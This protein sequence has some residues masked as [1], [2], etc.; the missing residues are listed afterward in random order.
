MTTANITITDFILDKHPPEP[1]Y[2]THF[3]CGKI[4]TLP[5]SLAGG[6]C[7]THAGNCKIRQ[8]S[9]LQNQNTATVTIADYNGKNDNRQHLP[10]RFK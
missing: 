9:L 6:K 10:H 2:C 5:E 8:F 1:S 3:G 4:L 7:L